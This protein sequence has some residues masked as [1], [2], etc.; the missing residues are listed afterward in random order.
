MYIMKKIIFSLVLLLCCMVSEKVSAQ[1]VSPQQ[2]IQFARSIVGNDSCDYY[3]AQVGPIVYP[4]DPS[5]KMMQPWLVF[6]DE[7]PNS[8]WEHPCKYVYINRFQILSRDK[9]Y[10]VVDSV[11]PPNNI[12]VKSN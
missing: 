3:L 2:A 4:D 11:C 12:I 8:G 7:E 6:V 9:D 1:F 5:Y 10:F